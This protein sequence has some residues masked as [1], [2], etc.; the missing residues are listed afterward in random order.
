MFDIIRGDVLLTVWKW[1]RHFNDPFI[2]VSFDHLLHTFLAYSVA[3]AIQ[4]VAH[5]S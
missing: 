1:T 5:S 4:V 3:A 2:D